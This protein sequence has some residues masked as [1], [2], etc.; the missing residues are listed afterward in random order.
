VAAASIIRKYLI[1]YI[2]YQ[3]TRKKDRSA[4]EEEEKERKNIRVSQKCFP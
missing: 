1:T 4:I 3:N 2:V